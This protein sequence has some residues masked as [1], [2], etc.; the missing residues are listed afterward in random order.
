M[1]WYKVKLLAI[2]IAERLDADQNLVGR[3]AELYKCD[4]MTDMVGEFSDLQGIMGRYY[5][6]KDNEPSEVSAAMDEVYMPRFAG[7]QLPKS[8]TGLILALAERMD[9]L[10]GI[11]GIGQIPTGAKDPFALRRA[12]IYNTFQGLYII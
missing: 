10:V 2:T 11:F 9:T 6:K 1:C 4:L 8:K 7:D 5:A 3:A 12:G